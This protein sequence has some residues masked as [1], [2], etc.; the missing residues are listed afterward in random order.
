MKMNFRSFTTWKIGDFI[1]QLLV[2]I[3]G[4]VVTFAASNAV[5]ERTKAK[6]VAKAM[7]IVRNEL[8]RN[9]KDFDQITERLRLEQRICRYIRSYEKHIEDAS[10]DTLR[11]YLSMPFQV[12]SFIPASDAMEMLRASSLLPNVEN[13]EL[14]LDILKAY[15]GLQEVKETVDWYYTTKQDRGTPLSLHENFNRE[16]EEI[17]NK[18]RERDIY[19]VIKYQLSSIH[20]HNILVLGAVGIEFEERFRDIRQ[21]LTQAIEKID[22]EYGR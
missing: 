4:I 13:K 21:I 1:L 5:S 8:E 18:E 17:L 7:E 10:A 19:K 20:I 22:R 14:V 12:S 11:K 3:L 6:E 15:N 9:L 2:V 16:Y